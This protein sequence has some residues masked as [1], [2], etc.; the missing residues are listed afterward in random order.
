MS[1]PSSRVLQVLGIATAVLLVA[2]LFHPATF[3]APYAGEHTSQYSH[4]LVSEWEGDG[5]LAV[6]EYDELSPVAREL[7]DRTREADGS[8]SPDVC[9]EFMLVCDGYYEDELPDEFTYGAYLSPPESHVIVEEGDERYVLK[10]GQGSV[11]AIYFDTGGIVS[12]VTLIPTALF[13]VFA[14]GAN[15]II[16]TAAADRVLGASVAG[17]ATLGAL[18]MLAPYLEMY[19]V[20]TAERLGRWVIAA[21]YAGFVELGFLREVVADLLRVVVVDL[22]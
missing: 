11:Q 7:F 3:A 21:L 14:V 17:G 15:R 9:A 20:V 5:D 4:E 16:G 8:Y 2:L 19:G 10:T 6:Y 1:L 12:F 22:L 13:L 18:S